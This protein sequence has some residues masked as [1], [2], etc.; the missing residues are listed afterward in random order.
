MSLL[1]G[2]GQKQVVTSP[3]PKPYFPSCP[4]IMDLER[5]EAP[6]SAWRDWVAVVNIMLKLREQQPEGEKHVLFTCSN[7]QP[8]NKQL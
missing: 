2:C 7:K 8:D 3:V 6:D 4:T 1:I 5:D